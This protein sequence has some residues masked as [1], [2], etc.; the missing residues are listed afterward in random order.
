MV[1]DLGFKT[2]VT[3]FACGLDI[4]NDFYIYSNTFRP[5]NGPVDTSTAPEL[6]RWRGKREQNEEN[7]R[8]LVFIEAQILYL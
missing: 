8:I 5:L 3:N 7:I 2:I 4:P 6:L 1:S